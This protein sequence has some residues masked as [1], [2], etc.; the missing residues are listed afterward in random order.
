MTREDLANYVNS[1]QK[2]RDKDPDQ[3][4]ISTQ[5]TLGLPSR[6]FFKWLVYPDMT[7]QERKYLRRDRFPPAVKGVVLQT[8]KDSKTPIKQKD[9]WDDKDTA[10]FLRY[11]TDNPR[12]R[13]Y[14]G[15]AYQT[16][17]RPSELLQLKIGDIE[18]QTDE[19]GKFCALIDVGRYGKKK[20]SRIVVQ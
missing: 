11:C 10:I 18:I 7:P 6:K 14:H 20:Q 12:H 9:I 15:L 8:K 2:E 19:N 17:A 5:R 4:W 13:F 16:S 1:Y 3:S